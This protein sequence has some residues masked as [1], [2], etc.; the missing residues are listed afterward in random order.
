M[1]ACMLLCCRVARF[2]VVIPSRWSSPR[3][4]PVAVNNPTPRG[5]FYA[6]DRIHNRQSLIHVA[7]ETSR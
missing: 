5:H 2:D 1:L 7:A 6:M 3:L 4:A